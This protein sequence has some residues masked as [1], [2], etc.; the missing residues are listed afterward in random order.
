MR[1][2]SLDLLV[3]TDARPRNED[4]CQRDI[5]ECAPNLE[6]RLGAGESACADVF[7]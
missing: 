4:A 1:R 2:L 5:G 6:A 7:T 3:R